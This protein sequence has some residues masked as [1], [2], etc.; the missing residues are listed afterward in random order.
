[1]IRLQHAGVVASWSLFASA[2]LC[3]S[4]IAACGDEESPDEIPLEQSA[5]DQSASDQASDEPTEEEVREAVQGVL[6][7]ARAASNEGTESAPAD[8]PP[9]ETFV[10]FVFGGEAQRMTELPAAEQRAST[11]D[12]VVA[13]RGA[14]G[15]ELMVEVSGFDVF[16][17]EPPVTLRDGVQ[18]TYRNTDGQSWSG[19]P[20]EITLTAVDEM[21]IEGT[22][23]N[24]DLNPAEGTA[25]PKPIEDLRFQVELT[26]NL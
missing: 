26:P 7:R 1:M 9:D 8:A 2:T 5:S 3:A 17:A 11:T 20:T 13:A 24:L 10:A 16:A 19:E 22:V 23:A 12:F 25:P 6:D 4:M 14:N 21:W 18:L 15:D